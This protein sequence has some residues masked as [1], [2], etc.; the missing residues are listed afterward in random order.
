MREQ[1]QAIDAITDD[2]Q[3]LE[4]SHT[5]MNQKIDKLQQLEQVIDQL[6][7]MMEEAGEKQ[8]AQKRGRS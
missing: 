6:D 7:N 5:E 8:V 2:T 1:Q 4:K 3:F